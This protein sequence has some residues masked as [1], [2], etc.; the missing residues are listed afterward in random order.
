MNSKEPKIKKVTVIGRNF[1]S[2]LCV[3]SLLKK[4][5]T[6]INWMQHHFDTATRDKE[7]W[8]FIPDSRQIDLE[9]KGLIKVLPEKIAVYVGKSK[10]VPLPRFLEEGKLGTTS[11]LCLQ[12]SIR[13]KIFATAI[14]SDLTPS[15]W[16]N[17]HPNVNWTH[18]TP[19]SAKVKEW[20]GPAILPREAALR[21]VEKSFTKQG[22]TL[23]P[24]NKLVLGME[25][26]RLG[27]DNHILHNAPHSFTRS[28]NTIWCNPHDAKLKAQ[29][30]VIA[31]WVSHYAEVEKRL[32]SPLPLMS[33]WLH[34]NHESELLETGL[35]TSGGLSRVFVLPKDEKHN[36]IQIQEL[37]FL[38]MRSH[39]SEIRPDSFLWQLC[40]Y[41]RDV[42]LS[43]TRV[44]CDED[45]LFPSPLESCKR[46]GKKTYFVWPGSLGSSTDLMNRIL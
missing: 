29:Q 9:V 1:Y 44:I 5:N 11:E 28:Q 35:I 3:N 18:Q 27:D 33:I 10:R 12:P 30:P 21:A 25:Q 23:S 43:F 45:I 16:S 36:L 19:L 39:S 4:E 2:A 38:P 40:P 17:G 20:Q 7:D 14:W 31:R 46:I 32:I 22:V 8:V 15:M 42:K 6:R 24:K 34:E 26:G 37:E 41:L 13:A